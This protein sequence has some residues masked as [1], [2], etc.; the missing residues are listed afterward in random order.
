MTVLSTLNALANDVLKANPVPIFKLIVDGL[1]ISSKINNRLIQM[2]IENKRGLSRYA[3]PLTF[4][5]RWFADN[6][7]QRG[8]S[9]SM[10]RLAA[11][12]LG[13]QGQLHRQ[14]G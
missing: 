6:P 3:R 2:R 13:L 1:D 11:F 8:N 9:S 7:K 5:S 10:D 14:R 12:W 4:R